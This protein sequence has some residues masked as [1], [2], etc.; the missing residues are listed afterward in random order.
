MGL[1]SFFQSFAT[2]I[3]V[4]LMLIDKCYSTEPQPYHAS[5]MRKRNEMPTPTRSLLT[6]D[7]FDSQCNQVVVVGRC[8]A[9]LNRFAYFEG[10]CR[11]FVFEAV[12]G[13]ITILKLWRSAE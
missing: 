8:R 3:F 11:P 2:M 13:T 7:S 6:E 10:D 4:V 5:S 12:G 9:E 1:M